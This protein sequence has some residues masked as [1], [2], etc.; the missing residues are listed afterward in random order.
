VKLSVTETKA[1]WDGCKAK[2]AGAAGGH[3][4]RERTKS[5]S[6]CTNNAILIPS[7]GMSTNHKLK[8]VSPADGLVKTVNSIYPD[9]K[10]QR[11]SKEQKRKEVEKDAAMQSKLIVEM[12]SRLHCLLL[13]V[14]KGMGTPEELF[15]SFAKAVGKVQNDDKL[16]E[17]ARSDYKRI[18]LEYACGT[19]E[20][21]NH[22]NLGCHADTNKSHPTESMM[23]FGKVFCNTG[24]TAYDTISNMKDAKLFLPH[25]GIVLKLRCGR[26]VLHCRFAKT[27]HAPDAMRGINNHSWVH[28]P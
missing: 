23:V 12:N 1:I 19:G 8:Y 9:I 24:D 25:E 13:L 28:G 5:Q 21:R 26:D 20:F 2:Q 10:G 22:F 14:E 18:L 11:L 4:I 27:Y 7:N 17:N 16:W 15:G 6:A 3:V